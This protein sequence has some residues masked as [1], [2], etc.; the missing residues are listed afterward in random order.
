MLIVHTHPSKS[1]IITQINSISTG[2]TALISPQTTTTIILTQIN[3]NQITIHPITQHHQH[4]PSTI[5]QSV[6]VTTQPTTNL[7]QLIE[8]VGEQIQEE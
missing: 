3:P 2:R 6:P 4:H 8:V 5:H 1:I 7:T